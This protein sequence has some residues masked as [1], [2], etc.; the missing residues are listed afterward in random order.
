MEGFPALYRP[1]GPDTFEIFLLPQEF[2]IKRSCR[3]YIPLGDRECPEF[4][5]APA[6]A[7]RFITCRP[8]EFR[9]LEKDR[10]LTG[11]E[12]AEDFKMV[13]YSLGRESGPHIP[14]R[15]LAINREF[16]P[17][18]DKIAIEI[19]NKIMSLSC[20]VSQVFHR[21]LGNGIPEFP[22][23]ESTNSVNYGNRMDPFV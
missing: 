13:S 10:V 1:A 7:D 8:G 18:H 4:S 17:G 21:I 9:P 20:R 23:Y 12:G 2:F 11:D 19:E 22:R 16:P 5:S 14:I 6:R 15:Y 3:L